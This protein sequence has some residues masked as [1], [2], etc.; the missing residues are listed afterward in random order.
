MVTEASRTSALGL[1]SNKLHMEQSVL[2]VQ[3]STIAQAPEKRWH[4]INCCWF[5]LHY[6]FLSHFIW[7]IDILLLKHTA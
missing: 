4:Q 1:T 7:D 2:H 6:L 3:D 5:D